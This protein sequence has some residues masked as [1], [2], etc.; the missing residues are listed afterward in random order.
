[1]DSDSKL[2]ILGQVTLDFLNKTKS[3]EKELRKELK[4]GSRLKDFG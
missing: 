3:M 1:M 2:T 4:T